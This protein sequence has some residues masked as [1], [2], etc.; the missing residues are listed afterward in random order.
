MPKLKC[1]IREYI[2]RWDRGQRAKQSFARSRRGR[3]RLDQLNAILP[4]GTGG[5]VPPSAQAQVLTN[6]LLTVPSQ[7]EQKQ[8]QPQ[9]YQQFFSQYPMRNAYQFGLHPVQALHSQSYAIHGNYLLGTHPQESIAPP[10]YSSA[11]GRDKNSEG[12]KKRRCMNCFNFGGENGQQ[13]VH[14]CAGSTPRGTCE[15]FDISGARIKDS[16]E[17]PEARNKRKRKS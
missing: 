2:K 4:A 11:R 12:R 6:Q 17:P 7:A 9:H 8:Q 13:W 14:L 3:E 10:A 5:N 15:Y 1:H 16:S